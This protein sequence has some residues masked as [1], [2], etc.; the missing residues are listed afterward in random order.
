MAHRNSEK[1]W[2]AALLVSLVFGTFAWVFGLAISLCELLG[3]LADQA[4]ISRFGVGML[5]TTFPTAIFAAHC[6]DKAKGA[7]TALRDECRQKD[8]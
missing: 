1:R 7:K 2:V 8:L 5:L 4:V 3:L 6:L